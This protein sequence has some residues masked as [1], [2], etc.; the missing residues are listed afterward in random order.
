MAVVTS[1]VQCE[2]G[3]G[4]R[5]TWLLHRLLNTVH[6]EQ[7]SITLAYKVEIIIVETNDTG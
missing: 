6:T 7:G 4:E 1:T 3:G 5:E 2:G